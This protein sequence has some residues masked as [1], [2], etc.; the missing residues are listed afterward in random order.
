MIEFKNAA[1]GWYTASLF[2]EKCLD[3]GTASEAPYC[4]YSDPSRTKG[5][6]DCQKTFVEVGDPTG[7]KWSEKYIGG[8]NHFMFLMKASWFREAFEFWNE[9]LSKKNEVEALEI[10]KEISKDETSKARF[11]AAKFMVDYSTKKPST[12]RGRPTQEE[13]SGELKKEVEAR[14]STVDDAERIGLRVING[15][16]Q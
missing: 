12:K 15:G 16:K 4:L 10:I 2:Y 6:I 8:Y 9:N 14:K 1:N 13:I 11:Q 7:V 5:R 3:N